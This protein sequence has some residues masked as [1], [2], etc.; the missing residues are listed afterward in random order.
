MQTVIRAIVIIEVIK[1]QLIVQ[2]MTIDTESC[3]IGP[4]PR[5]ILNRVATTTKQKER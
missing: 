5:D 1:R 4:T 2:I 3:F